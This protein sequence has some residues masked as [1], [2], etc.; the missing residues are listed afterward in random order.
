MK[1]HNLKGA[2]AWVVPL[3]KPLFTGQDPAKR[4]RTIQIMAPLTCDEGGV[5]PAQSIVLYGQ[6]EVLLTGLQGIID[7][8]KKD[9]HPAE[10]DPQ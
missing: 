3:P 6:A 9:L 1:A 10:E 5:I 2:V 7:D 4:F 8:L